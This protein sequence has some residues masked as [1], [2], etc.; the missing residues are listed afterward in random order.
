M[1]GTVIVDDE[2]TY[3]TW[4]NMQPTFAQASASAQ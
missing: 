4:L 3:E 2:S 1:R